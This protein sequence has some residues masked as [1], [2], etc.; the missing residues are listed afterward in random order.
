MWSTFKYKDENHF[1]HYNV[2]KILLP[3]LAQMFHKLL[4]APLDL[5]VLPGVLGCRFLRRTPQVRLEA[6]PAAPR[7]GYP[8]TRPSSWSR[9]NNS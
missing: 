9:D 2:L 4:A 3:T 8:V 6:N 7:D 5:A 1:F